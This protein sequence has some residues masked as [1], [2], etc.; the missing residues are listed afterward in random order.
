M[1]LSR[2][3]FYSALTSCLAHSVALG[4]AAT[5]IIASPQESARPIKVTLLQRAT[6]L[7]VGE[8]RAAEEPAA[9]PAE[10]SPAPASVLQTSSRSK[11]KPVAK[12]R[13]QRPAPPKI[14]RT[15]PALPN[16]PSPPPALVRSSEPQETPLQVAAVNSA[17]TTDAETDNAPSLHTGPVIGGDEGKAETGKVKGLAKA[18]SSRGGGTGIAAQPNYG[19]NPKPPYPMLARRLGAQGVVLLRIQVREDGTVATVEL[20]RSSGFAM[21]DDSATRTV[22]ESWQFVPA[23]IDGTPVASWVEVPIRFVLEDS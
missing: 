15:P 7:L 1:S 17:V 10:K 19:V 21:L 2:P 4:F 5:L 11:P 6:P 18:G 22:R 12:P 16:P 13:R 9:I 20:A 23:R 3:V 8:G 14:V